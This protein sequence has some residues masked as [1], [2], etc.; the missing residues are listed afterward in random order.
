MLLIKR[1]YFEAIRAGTKTTTLRYWRWARVR[2]GSVHKVPGLGLVR[3]DI[4]QFASEARLTDSDARADGFVSLDDLLRA[5][6]QMYPPQ[7]RNG[8][9][10]YHVH[11]TYLR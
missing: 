2:P 7:S 9:R 6:R 11:F 4:V 3:I 5:L 10:L 8:R 1:Q